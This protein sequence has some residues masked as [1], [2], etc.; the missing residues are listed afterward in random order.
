MSRERS[1]ADGSVFVLFLNEFA[2]KERGN[3][4]NG[5]LWESVL[6]RECPGRLLSLW[7]SGLLGTGSRN[8]L[9]TPREREAEATDNQSSRA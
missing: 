2:S 1:R 8:S 5:C 4:K 9:R 7:D 6:S 3:E